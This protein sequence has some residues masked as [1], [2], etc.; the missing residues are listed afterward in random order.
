MVQGTIH[1]I[2]SSAVDIGAIH[3][4]ASAI[5]EVKI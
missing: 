3:H 4:W 1:V 5:A 2:S